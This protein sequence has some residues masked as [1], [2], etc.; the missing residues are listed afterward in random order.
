MKQPTAARLW[1]PG[2]DSVGAPH[3]W[4]M[5]NVYRALAFVVQCAVLGLAIA[6]VVGLYAPQ[7][8]ERLRGALGLHVAPPP[9]VV[10]LQASAPVVAQPASAPVISPSER[11]HISENLTVS[12]ADAVKHA[13]P[14]VVSIYAN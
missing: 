7:S 4:P 3:T 10:N 5:K 6:F 1:S 13:A 8:T 11:E 9:A 12:Y 2:S 14:S